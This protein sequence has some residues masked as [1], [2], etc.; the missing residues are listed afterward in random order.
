M[1]FRDPSSPRFK[2]KSKK[3]SNNNQLRSLL[4]LSLDENNLVGNSYVAR[5]DE[6]GKGLSV[7]V[8]EEQLCS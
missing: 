1:S 6:F 3:H 8:V 4:V 7:L 2:K 5:I